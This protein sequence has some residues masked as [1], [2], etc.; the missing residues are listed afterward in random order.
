MPQPV[1]SLWGYLLEWGEQVEKS[2]KGMPEIVAAMKSERPTKERLAQLADEM[3]KVCQVYDGRKR[4]PRSAELVNSVLKIADL[5]HRRAKQILPTSVFAVPQ[6]VWSP[7]PEFRLPFLAIQQTFSGLL[8]PDVSQYPVSDHIRG[9]SHLSAVFARLLIAELGQQKVC[10]TPLELFFDG[11]RWGFESWVDPFI[12]NFRSGLSLIPTRQKRGYVTVASLLEEDQNFSLE[13][14]AAL[15]KHI[16]TSCI[17][18]HADWGFFFFSW[19]ADGIDHQNALV[20]DFDSKTAEIFE[21][22]GM[23]VFNAP[24]FQPYLNRLRNVVDKLVLPAFGAGF[25]L[26]ETSECPNI[27]AQSSQS[28]FARRSGRTEGGFC[29]AWTL[30]NLHIRL[31]NPARSRTELESQLLRP[32][33]SHASDMANREWLDTYIRKYVSYVNTVAELNYKRL[34]RLKIG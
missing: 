3:V 16:Q 8:M 27:G 5:A 4:T 1:Q 34:H 15:E 11:D 2:L 7:T 26:V 6:S 33:S 14:M 30:L 20:V 28:K 29:V 21:P 17:A 22:N 25:K 31:L 18:A 19:H 32:V 23:D 12:I 24:S 10:T 13:R 9:H